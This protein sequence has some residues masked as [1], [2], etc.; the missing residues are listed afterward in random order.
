MLSLFAINHSF[1]LF[2]SFFFFSI[3]IISSILVIY[4]EN[5]VYSVLYL[6]LVF[7]NAG[8]LFLLFNAE[9]L[10][11]IVLI[12]YVGAIAVLFL[13][14]VMMLNV[15]L[16]EVQSRF[17]QYLPLAS[18]LGVVLFIELFITTR[19]FL[20]PTTIPF[21]SLPVFVN[22]VDLL[23]TPSNVQLIGYI[24]FTFKY[25]TLLLSSLILLIAMLGSI[26]LTIDNKA[27]VRRQDIRDQL[28]VP[29][30]YGNLMRGFL[31]NKNERLNEKD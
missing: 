1:F 8:M 17:Y 12:I 26:V 31:K 4:T 9:F 23:V 20:F 18:F 14:V 11:F 10:A 29:Y 24:I 3:I 21:N 28:N 22:W 19:S 15:K 27:N 30:T 5:T 16:L 25:T 13:F 7:F 6:V 2:L